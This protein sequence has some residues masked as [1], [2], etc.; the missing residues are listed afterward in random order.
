M[1]SILPCSSIL[2]YPPGLP[3]AMLYTGGGGS[4]RGRGGGWERGRGVGDISIQLPYTA[5][6]NGACP[7]GTSHNNGPGHFF[8]PGSVRCERSQRPEL[9]TTPRAIAPA[10]TV[11]SQTRFQAPGQSG[12]DLSGNLRRKERLQGAGVYSTTLGQNARTFFK[13][14]VVHQGAPPPDS[15]LDQ[16]LG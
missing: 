1:S 6:P 16:P 13:V 3:P 4:G 9:R 11:A 14:A 7:K 10:R 5:L 8:T 15:I 2:P 12:G